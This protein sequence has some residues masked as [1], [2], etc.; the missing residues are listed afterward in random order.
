[1]PFEDWIRKDPDTQLD[2]YEYLHRNR[3][4]EKDP[5]SDRGPFKKDE[6]EIT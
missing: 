1:M 4:K 6:D 3:P 5:G 2:W